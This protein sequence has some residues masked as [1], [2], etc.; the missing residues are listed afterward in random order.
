MYLVFRDIADETLSPYKLARLQ[1]IEENRKV[2]E[3]RF[4]DQCK[5]RR[6]QYKKDIY[7]QYH[8]LMYYPVYMFMCIKAICLYPLALQIKKSTP[9]GVE[10]VEVHL[11]D[12]IAMTSTKY[13]DKPII[14]QVTSTGHNITIDW[15]IGT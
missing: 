10:D 13:K 5:S 1:Q 14:G 8:S 12:F 3:A 7:V 15:Y 2:V 11:G 9:E 6:E 4:K